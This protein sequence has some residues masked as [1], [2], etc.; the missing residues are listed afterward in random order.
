V[1]QSIQD[2]DPG[3]KGDGYTS[4]S[5]IYG[6]FSI[7]NWL[8]PSIVAVISAKWSMIFGAVL[9]TTFIATFLYP[10]TW[11]LYGMS[12]VLGLGAAGIYICKK[13]HKKTTK[14]IIIIFIVK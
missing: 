8:A 3:F 10:M 5:I 14:A 12:A 9:Y 4:L 11:L 2:D 1:L 7:S 6:V 13:I